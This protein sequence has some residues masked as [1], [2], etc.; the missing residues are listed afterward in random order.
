MDGVVDCIT[1]QLEKENPIYGDFDADGYKHSGFI[2]ISKS[3]MFADYIPDRVERLQINEAAL[4][5]IDSAEQP[6]NHC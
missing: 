5:I 4:K 6:D 3:K 1:K 2:F